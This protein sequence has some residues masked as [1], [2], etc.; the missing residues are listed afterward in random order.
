[1][2][3]VTM[4]LQSSAEVG[5]FQSFVAFLERKR[6]EISGMSPVELGAAVTAL[7][8]KQLAQSEPAVPVA[9]ES[10][11]PADEPELRV[12]RQSVTEQQ[13]VAKVREY[14]ALHGV[15]KTGELLAEFDAKRVSD[16]PKERWGEFYA[17]V[18]A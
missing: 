9:A 4:L 8:E 6:L 13:L 17:R 12:Q 5:A 7:A 14:A 11:P 15:A 18:S 16:L 10:Q 3:E 1:M 2:V